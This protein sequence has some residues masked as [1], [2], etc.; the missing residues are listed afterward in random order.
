MSPTLCLNMIVKNESHVIV[1]TLEHLVSK[2]PFNYWVI[3]DTGST[4][5]TKELIRAFF[6]EKQIPGELFDH[7]WHDFGYNRTKALEC[8]YNKTDLLF[9]FDADDRIHG[10]IILPNSVEFEAYFMKFGDKYLYHR[11]LLVNNRVKFI[12][13]GV[14]HEVLL[15]LNDLPIN[16]TYLQG[17][18]HIESRQLGDRSK[19][20]KKYVDDAETIKKAY[21]KALEEND[22]FLVCRYAF[23]CAQSYRDAGKEY[24]DLSC[25]W[26]K[27]CLDLENGYQEK[28]V[29]AM[30]IAV[31]YKLKND[32]ENALKYWY[33]TVEYDNDRIEGIA[34]IMNHLI[35]TG[36]YVIVNALYYKFKN[37]TLTRIGKLFLN[38][39]PYI[40][41]DIEYYAAISC[42]Y[43]KDYSVGYNCCKKI[44]SS[45]DTNNERLLKTFIILSMYKEQ[46]INEKNSKDIYDIFYKLD[47]V[48]QTRSKNGIKIETG[49]FDLWNILFE[50]LKSDI[51]LKREYNFVNK[52][53]P[54]VLLS[55]TTCK[56][57]ELFEKT[58]NSILN[59]WTDKERIDY[60]FCVDDNSCEDDR[61]KMRENYKWLDFYMKTPDEK[62]HRQSMNIIWNKLCQLKPIYWIHMEDDFIFYK[63]MD[64]VT[65]AL[66]A[67][68]LLRTDNVKQVLFNRNYAETIENY[69]TIGH[70]STEIDD[71]V[72][73][74][75]DASILPE[76]SNCH[77]W[78]HYSFRPS[79]V[80]VKTILE[81]GNFDSAN[82][83]F[84]R[85]YANKYEAKG[86][87]SAFFNRITCKHIG[88]LTY[89][90]N[91]G[92]DNAYSLN[93]ETQ[94]NNE[95]KSQNVDANTIDIDTD[96]INTIFEN[97]VEELPII[98]LNLER[99]SDRKEYME[100]LLK[101]ASITDY[102]FTKAIDGK[103]LN[104]DE[105]ILKIF[106]G[107]DFQN[108][109][110]VIGCALSH[111]LLWIQLLKDDKN[112]YYIIIED[113]VTICNDFKNKLSS[114][115]SEFKEKEL[116]FMGYSMFQKKRD[117][118]RH[119][120]DSEEPFVIIEKLNKD[121]YIG[122][123]FCYSINKQGAFKMLSYINNNG[124]KHG[125]D[126]LMKIND[127]VDS[128]ESRPLLAFSDWNENGSKIDS[129]I[130]NIK[131]SIQFYAEDVPSKI[132]RIKMLCNWTSSQELC[133][134][135]SNMCDNG[136]RWK[137]IEITWTNDNI[138]Y[139]VIVNSP[140][141]NEYYD[142]NRTIVFQME[143]W[144][145]D[146]N[147]NWGV[148]TW[149]EWAIP[150]P[151]KFLH[152]R[153]RKTN[154]HNNAFWQLELTLSQLTS[155]RIEKTKC[156]SSI[157]SSKFFDEGHIARLKLLKYI[158]SKKDV[159][160]DIYNKDN[161]AQF[162]NYKGPV[163]P[164]IDK[165]KGMLTYK[166]YFM[167]E[168][169][170]EENF[171][172]EKLWEPILCESL[173]FYYGCP[174]AHEYIDNRAFV[175]LDV[176][177]F[178]KSYQTIKRA[179]EED[180]WSQR[181]DIIR[182][183]KQRILNELAFFPT[184]HKII[185]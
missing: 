10:E 37:Y 78:P 83:F 123:T 18:Y 13:K 71:F 165:S 38:A 142:P 34:F 116:I 28:Y 22:R 101:N 156:I 176:N 76:Y 3:S 68:N 21:D 51:V 15:K 96:D 57:Y 126:Y 99:R 107:N 146:T 169:S 106:K 148:K 168:N 179:I 119:I 87:K 113:D 167:I 1:E 152:V 93:N 82:T 80:D 129:D 2:I 109:R 141:K 54:F 102:K 177:D 180:W 73:H 183:E 122:G 112:D 125:I 98:I 67:I 85:D 69:N 44:I 175:L 163:S 9:I 166:Y 155:M 158:E 31:M 135:W 53:R 143:P 159:I 17:D 27:K 20:P 84:E 5:N 16:N 7:E 170:Y 147:K 35:E 138:D 110:G 40:N 63:Q 139:Y 171:I 137:N 174:N 104:P 160:I 154:H 50:L 26:Y 161:A 157:C 66:D 49:F 12:F 91:K 151:K 81:L 153:G 133:K 89:Q 23:Y 88:R 90:K 25:E 52:K 45:L 130:Q 150:D 94:F 178:E 124:I 55:F 172:T 42:H 95:N 182:K 65:K 108:R 56:R 120:Y 58:I 59:N 115:T 103:S 97:P 62:G 77:Y 60:W 118:V 181:I 39:I 43:I 162:I 11:P 6:N 144:I 127:D 79:L 70:I 114:L 173:V 134:E 140:P 33:K 86:Y 32:N 117:L 24:Y 128:Y 47:D 29:S 8:A 19:N 164:Y 64:Y 14:V 185:S 72:L 131:D 4:D 132:I 46:L 92:I 41:C 75:H 100:K 111:Y 121:L 74:K 61:V 136:F 36:Q 145:N 30:N 105:S 48:I 149:G 184:I